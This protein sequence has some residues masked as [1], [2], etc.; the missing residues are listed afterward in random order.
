[1]DFTDNFEIGRPERMVKFFGVIPYIAKRGFSYRGRLVRAD[2][3][4]CSILRVRKDLAVEPT[5]QALQPEQLYSY[6][7]LDNTFIYIEN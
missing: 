3:P 6:T 4:I 1:V 7:M 5:Y 2:I